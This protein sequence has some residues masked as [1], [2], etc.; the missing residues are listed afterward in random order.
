[1]EAENKAK[2]KAKI[3]ISI[4]NQIKKALLQSRAFPNRS[5]I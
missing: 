5:T 3:K 1:M 2:V 4:L